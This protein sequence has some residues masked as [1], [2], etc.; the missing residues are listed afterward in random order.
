MPAHK[1]DKK[2]IEQRIAAIKGQH[3]VCRYDDGEYNMI[4]IMCGDGGWLGSSRFPQFSGG[5]GEYEKNKCK[6]HHKVF[7]SV[8]A[9]NEAGK[10]TGKTYFVLSFTAAT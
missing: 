7:D 5:M 8:E 1:P 6:H 3:Y 10:A 2:L 4:F 9:A